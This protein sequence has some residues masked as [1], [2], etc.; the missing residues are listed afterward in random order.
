MRVNYSKMLEKK[1]LQYLNGLVNEP[2][3]F[4]SNLTRY[5]ASPPHHLEARG[6]LI[7][8]CSMVAESVVEFSYGRHTD[9][10]GNDYLERLYRIQEMI[11]K[12][13]FGYVVDLAPF[14]MWNSFHGV[15]SLTLTFFAVKHL[16]SWLPGMKFKRDAAKWK[17]QVDEARALMFSR[18]V[19]DMVS[20]PPSPLRVIC[21]A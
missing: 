19:K 6:H 15:P 8:A 12:A 2:D 17:A 21:V 7:I 13:S 9:E 10:V 4:L 3:K 14:R 16:P 5:R 20:V 18:A 1:W 11:V